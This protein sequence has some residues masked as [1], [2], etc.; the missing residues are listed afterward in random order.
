MPIMEERQGG[1]I[2]PELEITMH[3]VMEKLTKLNVDKSPG[4][5]GMHP[6]VLHRLRKEL[7]TPLTKFFQLSAASGTLPEQWKTAHVSVLHKKQSRKSP[8][9]YRPVSLT[10][11]VC[12]TMESIIR[13]KIMTHMTDNAMFSKAQH[14]FRPGRSCVTQLLEVI[15][16]W[17]RILD[18]G[19]VVDAIYFDFAKAFDTVPRERLLLKCYAHGI[20]G[21]TLIWIRSFLTGRPQRVVVNGADSSW[22]QVTSGIP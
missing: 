19:G 12:K 6:Y 22:S 14:G 1:N 2:L 9:N 20:Q 10:S 4:P 7:V 5:D 21:S 16:S 3:E 17:T 11:V 8:S 18:A 15:E 13:D